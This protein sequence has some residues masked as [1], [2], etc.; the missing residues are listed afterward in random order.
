MDGCYI[1]NES[2]NG[3]DEAIRNKSWKKQENAKGVIQLHDFVFGI[4]KAA[5]YNGCCGSGWL[6]SVTRRYSL[7]KVNCKS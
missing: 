1:V 7:R 6:R 3:A 5:S 2:T 4:Y